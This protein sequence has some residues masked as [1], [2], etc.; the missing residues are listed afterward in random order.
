MQI[1]SIRGRPVGES[2]HISVKDVV[3]SVDPSELLRNPG[4]H[5]DEFAPVAGVT[6]QVVA[7]GV[8]PLVRLVRQL[9]LALLADV[10]VHVEILL[11]GHH[12]HRLLRPLH[13]GDS[14]PAGGTL[15]GEDPVKVVDTVDL[16][17]EVYSEGDS[18]KALIADAASEAARVESL[19]DGLEDALHDQVAADLTL[20]R[21]LLEAAV[22]IVLLAVDLPVDVVESLPSQCPAAAAADEAGGVVE[23]AHGL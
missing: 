6:Q 5:L 19:A 20:L 14:L 16:V 17:V 12:P 10:A 18:V 23:V 2:D 21:G 15:G 1:F 7:Q 3:L 22:E 4:A 11:H 9:H 13:R 8:A